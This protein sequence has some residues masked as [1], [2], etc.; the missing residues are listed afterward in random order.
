MTP[1]LRLFLAL[2]T[3]L[4]LFPVPSSSAETAALTGRL[5]EVLVDV[6]PSGDHPIAPVAAAARRVVACGIGSG[7]ADRDHALHMLRVGLRAYFARIGE[8]EYG[9]WASVQS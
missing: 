9:A 6:D 1:T 2:A 4:A 8:R 7:A 3:E 5:S